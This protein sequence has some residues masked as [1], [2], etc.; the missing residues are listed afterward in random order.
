MTGDRNDP[1]IAELLSARAGP[2]SGDVLTAVD[3][4]VR[5]TPQA[6]PPAFVRRGVFSQ[7]RWPLAAAAALV[8]LVIGL[9]ALAELAP[10]LIG[11]I[12]PGPGSTVPSPT[13]PSPPI[14][15][16]PGTS[17]L[18]TS[19]G[20]ASLAG[21]WST[22]DVDGSQMTVTLLAVGNGWDVT[23]VDARATACGG[24]PLTSHGTGVT[25]ENGIEASTVGGCV[26]Q[27]SAAPAMTTVFTYDPVT[28]SL[29][30]PTGIAAPAS[31]TWRR[32][33][34]APDAFDR[35]WTFQSGGETR[36]LLLSG[37]GVTRTV[38]YAETGSPRCGGLTFSADGSG[39]LGTEVGAGRILSVELS[40]GCEGAPA[41]ALS[42]RFEYLVESDSLVGPLDAAGG[43]L[44]QTVS[45]RF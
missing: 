25:V 29:S 42:W 21:L 34:G 31:Y 11:Q 39:R 14:T 1:E 15:A 43:S 30:S 18:A 22:I 41:Q 20:P 45:W 37:S 17:P 38:S 13:R 23:Y 28:D 8:V 9:A 6:G 40:G 36:S 16:T 27:P 35:D 26:G 44:P 32:G 7:P 12:P 4:S 5:R 19:I 3:A 24:S 10:G 2:L 33:P